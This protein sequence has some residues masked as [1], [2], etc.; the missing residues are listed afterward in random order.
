MKDRQMM[1]AKEQ[2]EAFPH[3]EALWEMTM[4]AKAVRGTDRGTVPQKLGK[5]S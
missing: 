3:G 1:H 2:Q 5:A 4:T